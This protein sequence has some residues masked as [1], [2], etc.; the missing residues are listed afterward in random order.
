MNARW[1]RLVLGAVLAISAG[2]PAWANALLDRDGDGLPDFASV[3]DWDGDGVRELADVQAAVDALTDPGPK[4][5]RVEAG[6]FVP[7][8]TPKGLHG[9]VELPSDTLLRCAGPGSTILVG[10]SASV[11]DLNRSVLTNADHVRGNRNIR[12]E[13]CQI[14]GGMPDTYDSR[15]WTAHGRMGVNFNR[16]TNGVVTGSFVHHTHHTCLYTKNS[17]NVRFEDNTLEDCGAYGDV[18]DLARKPAIYLFATHGGVTERVIVARN[19]ITRGALNTRRDDVID[20]VRDVEFVDNV[21]DNSP[22]PFA[23]RPPEKCI[24][25]RGV[26]GILISGNQCRHTAAVY[27]LGS[28]VYYN[29]GGSHPDANR[30]VTIEDLEITDVETGR[31]IMIGSRVDGVVLRRVRVAR[32]PLDQVCIAWQTPMRGLLLEDVLAQDCGGGGLL[33][34]GPGSGATAAERVRLERITVD[35]TDVVATDDAVRHHGIELQGTN[36]GIVLKDLSVRRFSGYGIQIGGNSAALVESS[37]VGIRV[38]GLPS[39]YRGRFTA[40]DLPACDGA[41]RGDWAVVVDAPSGVSCN[42]GGSTENRCRCRAGSWTDLAESGSRYGIRVAGDGSHG[43]LFDTLALDDI[44]GSWGLHLAGPQRDTWISTV[45]ATDAGQIRTLP[46]LGAVRVDP[47]ATNVT[48]TRASC[49][50][51]APGSPCVSGLSD[52]DGDGVG[53][54]A[55]NCPYA[56]NSPQRDSDGDGIGD[57]CE[58]TA[59]CGLGGEVLLPLAAL[60]LL[61]RMQRAAPRR[62]GTSR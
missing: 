8:L 10:L 49:M 36:R 13:N 57:A 6:T 37:L 39:G 1:H 52:S 15:S 22:S 12:I 32:T 25:I 53:D 31:G 45:S 29:D 17:T 30:D 55:D 24:T 51:T 5:V 34:T 14:D 35:G 44:S 42:G 61:R 33:Q 60:A 4:W 54:A 46:Q 7:S 27:V 18:N 47:G 19:R 40:R 48:V 50:G 43:N 9:L 58:A 2:G 11:T 16:V 41:S 23:Q 59:A 21:V 38:G 3:G 62:A 20:V 26:D 56:V 28:P